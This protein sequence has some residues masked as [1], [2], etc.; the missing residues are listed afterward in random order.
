[1]Q[2]YRD[3]KRAFRI[4][5]RLDIYERTEERKED[6]IGRVSNSSTILRISSPL[7]VLDTAKRGSYCKSTMISAA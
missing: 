4:Q 5:F 6:S 1:M 2:N 3:D 7:K